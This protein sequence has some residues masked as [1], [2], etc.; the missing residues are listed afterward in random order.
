MDPTSPYPTDRRAK[1]KIMS[2]IFPEVLDVA[3]CV[4]GIF[5]RFSHI[6][7]NLHSLLAR[8]NLL[9]TL[10][11][12]ETYL[13]CDDHKTPHALRLEHTSIPQD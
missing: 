8:N 5:H 6:Q 11:T 13:Q 9:L 10:S 1:V 7:Q 12:L 2:V 3:D 4:F